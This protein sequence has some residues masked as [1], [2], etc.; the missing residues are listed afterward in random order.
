MGKVLLGLIFLTLL[1][2]YN[3]YINVYKSWVLQLLNYRKINKST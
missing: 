1:L 3:I 2:E